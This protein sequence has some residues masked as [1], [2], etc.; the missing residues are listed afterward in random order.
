V[1][2][3]RNSL[4]N[5]ELVHYM[6]LMKMYPMGDEAMDTRFGMLLAK[7][8]GGIGMVQLK[9]G[10]TSKLR[11]IFN[12]EFWTRPHSLSGLKEKIMA[13]FRGLGMEGEE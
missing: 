9:R 6:A 12:R 8:D 7:L 13:A 1:G 2:E 3:L 4:T 5:T 10:K 11:P